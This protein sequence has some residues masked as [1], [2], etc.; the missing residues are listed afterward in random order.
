MTFQF[1]KSK[2]CCD[3]EVFQ[4][5]LEKRS[6]LMTPFFIFDDVINKAV[7]GQ[8]IMH[9]SCE[10]VIYCFDCHHFTIG[11]ADLNFNC[12]PCLELKLLVGGGKY[13]CFFYTTYTLFPWPF[14]LHTSKSTYNFPILTQTLLCRPVGVRCSKVPP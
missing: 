10:S 12:I 14:C 6:L 4:N 8:Q 5:L 9:Q 7:F 3:I 13:I 11:I 2:T 1:L